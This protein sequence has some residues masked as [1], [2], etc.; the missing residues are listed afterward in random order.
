MTHQ[1][2]E[3][4]ST[5]VFLFRCDGF[6]ARIKVTKIDNE[7]FPFVASHRLTWLDSSLDTSSI[8]PVLV[9][10]WRKSIDA[11][12]QALWPMSNWWIVTPL[13]LSIA[14]S[15]DLVKS[16]KKILKENQ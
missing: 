13:V 9:D 16:A 14:D 7:E 3:E 8:V 4:S 15:I 5:H 2:T 11:D 12:L 10:D 6:I 1:P